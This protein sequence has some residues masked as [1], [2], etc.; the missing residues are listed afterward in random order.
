MQQFGGDESPVK[1]KRRRPG[2]RQRERRKA[3]RAAAAAAAALAATTGGGNGMPYVGGN[4]G[5]GPLMPTSM[6]PL[7]VPGNAHNHHLLHQHHHLAGGG[8]DGSV[9]DAGRVASSDAPLQ[10]HAPPPRLAYNANS[11]TFHPHNG[12]LQF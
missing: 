3:A 10:L 9:L 4:N 8:F 5:T 11:S 1:T 12:A 6:T 7:G 2:K